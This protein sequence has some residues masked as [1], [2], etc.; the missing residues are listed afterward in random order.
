MI[1]R[2]T[3]TAGL[4]IASKV[5]GIPTA[6]LIINEPLS[7]NSGVYIG[8]TSFNGTSYPSIICYGIGSTNKFEVHLL[9]TNLNLYGETL[10]VD[11][12]EK[13]SEIVAEPDLE[14]LKTKILADVEKAKQH[15]RQM[16][17]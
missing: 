13:I 11:I 6:N 4:G 1:I 16:H 9:N 12:G 8:H 14:K 3:V 2:G 10:T 7:L 17:P 5:F 15:F